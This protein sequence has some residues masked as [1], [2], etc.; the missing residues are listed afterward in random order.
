MALRSPMTYID[1]IAKATLKIFHGKY[2]PVVPVTQSMELY[3]QIFL[4]YPGSKVFLDIFDGGH[5]IDMEAAMY[6]ILS[7]YR[8]CSQADVTG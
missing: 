5:Q 7:Q 8:C 4:K 6:W 3:Q 2:D 1:N